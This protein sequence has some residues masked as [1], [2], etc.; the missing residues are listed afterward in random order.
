MGQ[1]RRSLL[2]RWA[3]RYRWTCRI[4]FTNGAPTAE[5]AFTRAVVG[6]G[7][8]L[9][10]PR[11][12]PLTFSCV[13][14]EGLIC[15]SRLSFAGASCVTSDQGVVGNDLGEIRSEVEMFLSTRECVIHE[16]L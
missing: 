14:I 3:L 15:R 7:G 16:A 10:Q 5:A 4:H 8:S 1:H 12:S 11:T 9:T 13:G 2:V 6:P